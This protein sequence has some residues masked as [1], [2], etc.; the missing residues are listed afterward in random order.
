MLLYFTDNLCDNHDQILHVSGRCYWTITEFLN[1]THAHERCQA[2][3]GILAEIPNHE[4]QT[5]IE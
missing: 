3:D 1:F 4:A 2:D 5:K